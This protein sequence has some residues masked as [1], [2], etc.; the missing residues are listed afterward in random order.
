M[1]DDVSLHPRRDG[2]NWL[3]RQYNAETLVRLEYQ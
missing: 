2:Q 3:Y 1:H